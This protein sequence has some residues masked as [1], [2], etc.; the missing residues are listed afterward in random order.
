M[1]IVYKKRLNV[2]LCVHMYKISVV[3]LKFPLYRPYIKFDKGFVM[4]TL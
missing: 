4:F 3:C 2:N 1:Y